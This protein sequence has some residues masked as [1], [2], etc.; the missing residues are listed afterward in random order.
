MTPIWPIRY[1]L[2]LHSCPTTH[3][4]HRKEY[5]TPWSI[6]SGVPFPRVK[7]ALIHLRGRYSI[8]RYTRSALASTW[9]RSS[10]WTPM[11][12]GAK[13]VKNTVRVGSVT[14]H[15]GKHNRL[16]DKIISLIEKAAQGYIEK[17]V[18]L[19]VGR[20]IED[21]VTAALEH[22]AEEARPFLAPPKTWP[23]PP[24][25]SDA[26][27]W[28]TS[29]MY[30]LPSFLSRQREVRDGGSQSR[31]LGRGQGNTAPKA[32]RSLYHWTIPRRTTARGAKPNTSRL[33]N[34][35]TRRRAQ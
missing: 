31:A 5:N 7:Q 30:V 17:Q 26:L 33:I 23:E 1:S 32:R 10:S 21:K 14:I 19:L 13:V 15:F 34:T 16:I 35:S 27:I 20:F 9:K 18:V 29:Y 4:A 25:P 22:L 11:A 8:L 2:Q 12:V 6:G 28:R 3:R 24:L